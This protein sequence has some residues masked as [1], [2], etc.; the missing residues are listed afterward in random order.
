MSK[1]LTPNQ[2][3]DIQASCLKHVVE[4][5]RCIGATVRQFTLVELVKIK[6]HARRTST[7][8]SATSSTI[9][10]NLH[11]NKTEADYRC[12][13]L[14]EY[15]HVVCYKMF[16]KETA[17]H[18]PKWAMVMVALGEEPVRCHD[19]VLS[20][21]YPE[22][23]RRITCTVCMKSFDISNRKVNKVLKQGQHY[24]C[25]CGKELD[26]LKPEEKRIAARRNKELLTNVKPAYSIKCTKCGESIQITKRRYNMVRRGREYTHTHTL[27]RERCGGTMKIV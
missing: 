14:H 10:M 26:I 11:L 24:L 19:K 1:F 4:T 3:R 5:M 9:E 16:P 15:A 6:D 22:K 20:E 13:L 7:A 25:S 23:W 17:H 12:T 18:G 21:L 2:R 27:K 8:G